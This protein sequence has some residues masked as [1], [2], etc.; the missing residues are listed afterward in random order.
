MM[1]EARQDGNPHRASHQCEV[2]SLMAK[3]SIQE[4]FW[5]KVDQSSGPSACWTWKASAT[6]RGYGQFPIGRRKYGSHR[7]AWQLT[8]G[9][10]PKGLCVCHTYDVRTCVNPAHLWLGTHS[11]NMTDMWQKG[12][13]AINT[14]IGRPKL[15]IDDVKRIR[16]DGRSD[17]RIA[18]DYGIHRVTVG[19]IKRR[20][21]WAHVA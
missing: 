16:L 5:S 18:A 6:R 17:S 19:N 9:P 13:G 4:R 15:A 11:E 3:L 21:T 10:V 1:H 2:V 8:H 20:E 14:W 7:I 12:R